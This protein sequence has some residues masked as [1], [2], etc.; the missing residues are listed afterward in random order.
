MIQDTDT[1]RRI[2]TIVSRELRVDLDRVTPAAHLSRDLA[3][4][5]IDIVGIIVD[6]ED[7]YE[8]SFD[9]AEIEAVA[10]V[11]DLI[12]LI[13]PAAALPQAA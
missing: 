7:E 4:D 2:R 8:V 10:T 13:E 9:E 11:A 6:I 3:A 1:S 12:A 5:H